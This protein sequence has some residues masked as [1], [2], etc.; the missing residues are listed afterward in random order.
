MDAE[1]L[2]P[3]AWPLTDA[4]LEPPAILIELQDQ[5][6]AFVCV[7]RDDGLCNAGCYASSA[8]HVDE[9]HL[10]GTSIPGD[11]ELD[12]NVEYPNVEDM[13]WTVHEPEESA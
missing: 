5:V 9:W 11:I 12:L 8:G 6:H 7:E 3:Q 4:D 10:L 2:D 1:T 13:D